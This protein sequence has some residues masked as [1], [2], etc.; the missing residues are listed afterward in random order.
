MSSKINKNDVET[1]EEEF[2]GISTKKLI[3]AVV[4][5]SIFGFA[6]M[7][8]FPQNSGQGVIAATQEGENLVIKLSEVTSEAKFYYYKPNIVKIQFFAVLGT[9]D[10]PH[11]AIDACDS[12]YGAKK[13]YLHANP[14]MKCNNCG[15]TFLV[16]S[17]GTENLLGGCWPSYLP[18][19]IDDGNILIKISD[20]VTKE[21][22][23]A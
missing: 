22:M 5:I 3:T 14:Y 8:G 7:I 20:V 6:L 9:D 19:S 17:I 11:I 15:R 16:T 2:E 1:K 4:C 23:F 12:C 18:V 21:F 13:G 10:Q